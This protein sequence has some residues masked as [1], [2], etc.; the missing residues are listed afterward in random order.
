[1]RCHDKSI[2]HPRLVQ[3]K[4]HRVIRDNDLHY[5]QRALDQARAGMDAG[6]TPFG[7]CIVQG[8]RIL[9]Q[10]H[11]N[12]RGE[13]DC[14]AHAEVCALRQA[15][16]AAGD[17]HL[18]NATIYSTIEPC[19]M[20]FSAIHW[21]R[22]PRIVFGGHIADVAAYG[23]NELHLTNAFIKDWLGLKVTVTGGCCREQAVALFDQWQKRGGTAY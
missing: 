14:T 21:A 3:S 12:V 2:P 16:R 15:C 22:L 4:E 9:A 11:N 23:F 13:M 20:C 18:P 17:I 10:A 8:D 5:M 7:A 6:Q 1:M 19:P